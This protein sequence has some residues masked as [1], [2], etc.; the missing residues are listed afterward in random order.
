MERV[1]KLALNNFDTTPPSLQDAD[2][3]G[4]PVTEVT[5]NLASLYHHYY[6][7]FYGHAP[8]DPDPTR[9]EY[10]RFLSPT[11]DFRLSGE[12]IGDCTVIRRHSSTALGQAFCRW[13]LHDH[14]GM[15]YFAHMQ[16]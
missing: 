13:F 8:P 4:K 16:H 3:T 9:F 14:L 12:G 11:A 15:T 5:V 2:G 6:L 7:D 1:L 10:L